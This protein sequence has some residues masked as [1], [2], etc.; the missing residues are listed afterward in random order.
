MRDNDNGFKKVDLLETSKSSTN[1]FACLMPGEEQKPVTYAEG[2]VES[3][4]RTRTGH[5]Q[6][7][8][9]HAL[10]FGF[11]VAYHSLKGERVKRRL[12]SRMLHHLMDLREFIDNDDFNNVVNALCKS[13]QSEY[14]KSLAPWERSIERCLKTAS[15]MF[16]KRHRRRAFARMCLFLEHRLSRSEEPC[17]S[18]YP[19][20]LENQERLLELARYYRRESIFYGLVPVENR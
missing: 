1:P 4:G 12:V 16:G 7:H 6:H 15:R 5:E 8:A 2:L 17:M 3:Y 11:F 20:L 13:I 14:D 18:M 10:T 9:M 19:C